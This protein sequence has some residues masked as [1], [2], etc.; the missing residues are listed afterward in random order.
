MPAASD[1]VVLGA[2]SDPR[3]RKVVTVTKAGGGFGMHIA[4]GVDCATV[5]GFIDGPGGVPGPA[6]AAGAGGVRNDR[7]KAGRGRGTETG[8]APR[9][10]G[11]M[12]CKPA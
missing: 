10:T 7:R 9:G 6:V 3:V 8:R 4:S 5:S 1:S 11:G 2:G 12:E